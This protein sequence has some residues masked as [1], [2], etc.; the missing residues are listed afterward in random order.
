ME[1]NKPQN[2]TCFLPDCLECEK[3]ASGSCSSNGC[4]PEWVQAWESDKTKYS[5]VQVIGKGRPPSADVSD[6]VA[7]AASLLRAAL[8]PEGL[9]G[10]QY[11]VPG[12]DWPSIPSTETSHSPQSRADNLIARL[13]H[14]TGFMLKSIQRARR[15]KIHRKPGQV[16]R[17]RNMQEEAGEVCEHDKQQ[18][19]A[20]QENHDPIVEL[21]AVA[22]SSEETSPS[23]S[24]SP[25][26]DYPFGPGFRP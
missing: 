20:W 21:A 2:C 6:V 10:K 1:G 13:L 3:T 25:W 19:Q 24:E 4:F 23:N 15:D 11:I 26:G 9:G 7:N 17:P 14:V 5:L 16:G 8:S 22:K 18:G 12:P